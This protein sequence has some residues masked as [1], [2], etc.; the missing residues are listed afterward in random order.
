LTESSSPLVDLSK[1]LELLEAH[2]E[3]LKI[4]YQDNLR[5]SIEIE[6]SDLYKIPVMSLQPLLDNVT[7][8]NIISEIEPASVRLIYKNDE[9]YF[10]NALTTQ[11]QDVPSNGI[12]LYNLNERFK[13]L[14]D[15]EIKID[16]S[17]TE[18]IVVLPL[19]KK[20]KYGIA[21]RNY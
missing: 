16:K 20:K 18:F 5:I 6:N 11:K 14:L 2:I 7:K 3:L 19:V 8:H 1:E 15:K 21:H 10:I 9:L 13:L 4:R 17:D 12:G